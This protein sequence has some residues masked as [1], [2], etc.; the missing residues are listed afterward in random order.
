MRAWIGV[1]MLVLL[2]ACGRGVPQ[3]A[4]I[5]VAGDSVMAW[6]RVQGGSVAHVLSQTLGEPV[7]DVSL[8]FARVTGGRTGALD[9]TQQVEGLQAEWVVLNGGANDLRAACSC[10]GCDAML[11]RLIASD[12]RT[13]AIPAMVGDLRARGAKVL[14]ADYYTSPRFAGTACVGPYDTL[15]AR[16]ARLAALDPGVV[17]VDMGDVIPSS[18]LSLFDGDR[19]HPSAKGSARI[20]A[21]IA[22]RLRQAD[23]ARF[24]D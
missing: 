3:D 10:T 24:R 18:D 14:W 21:L 6:N 23:P 5:V 20:A 22:G 11:N 1:L 7:G 19:L 4:R 16:L 9:I 17:L 13:G 2:A 15:K 8:P 12:G